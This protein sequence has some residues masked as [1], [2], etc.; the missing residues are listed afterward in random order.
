MSSHPRLAAGFA[1]TGV[2]VVHFGDEHHALP[3]GMDNQ[4]R[5]NL[6]KNFAKSNSVFK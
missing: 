6:D 3:K 4:V 2:K 1:S 5:R